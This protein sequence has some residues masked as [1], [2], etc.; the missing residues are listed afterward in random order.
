MSTQADIPSDLTNNDKA[1]MFEYLDASLNSMIL[2]VL[3]HGMYTGI[4]AVTLWNIFMNNCWQMRQALVVV[5]ILLYGLTTIGFAAQW[6]WMHSALIDNGKSFWTAYSTLTYGS[7]AVMMLEGIASSMSTIITD[8]YIIWC[9]WMVWG[10]CWVTV[11][12]L[13][14]SI[15]AATESLYFDSIAVIAKGVAPTLLI[16]QAAAGHTHPN[17]DD[18]SV[19][20]VSSLHF[21]TASSEASTTSYQESTIES[22]VYETDIEAQQEQSDG[23]VEV[24]ERTE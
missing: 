19:T 20:T 1:I 16:G 13:I 15:V 22:A 12:L 18:D 8:L 7:Q 2:Y 21:Q 14:L 4:L 24:V 5:I 6:S 9:C 3:L 10:Q 11:L 23:L 17:D